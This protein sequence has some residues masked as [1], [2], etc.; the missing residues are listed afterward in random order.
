[1]TS[2]RKANPASQQ[3][4]KITDEELWTR[5]TEHDCHASLNLLHARYFEPLHAWLRQ[6]GIWDEARAADLV[7]DLWVRLVN[8]RTRF[9]PRMKWR[10]WA[11]HVAK[12]LASNERRRLQRRHV[13]PEA[14]FPPRD[15]ELAQVR[16]LVSRDRPDEMMRER[17]LNAVLERAVADLPDEQR[18]IFTLRFIDGRSND[19]VS[20]ALGTPISAL[21]AKAK[22]VRL[23][24]RREVFNLLDASC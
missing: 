4:A 12:N 21:K 23:T 22:R 19:E 8:N 11:F 16:E 24:V 10:T 1:M 14:D 6:C 7:Q 2:P 15:D 20:A 3:H 5:Y 13:T 9:N 18:L 17:E